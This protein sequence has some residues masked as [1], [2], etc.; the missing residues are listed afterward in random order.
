MFTCTC[1]CVCCLPLCS[2]CCT[3]KAISTWRWISDSLPCWRRMLWGWRWTLQAT[4]APGFTSSPFTSCAPWET[5]WVSSPVLALVW[6]KGQIGSL[7]MSL[8]R[9]MVK[10]RQQPFLSRAR[11]D[12]HWLFWFL[13]IGIVLFR[14]KFLNWW[15]CLAFEHLT[16]QASWSKLYCQ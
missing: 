10:P 3:W 7:V 2:S 6:V 16:I 1:N 12:A 15:I 9:T 5:V 11:R 14:F 13:A 4:R 8:Y